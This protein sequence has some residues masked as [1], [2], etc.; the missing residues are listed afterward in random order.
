MTLFSSQP[1]KYSPAWFDTFLPVIP[2]LQTEKELDF[3]M[4][5]ALEGKRGRVLDLCCGEGRHAFPAVERGCEVV[6]VDNNARIVERMSQKM[7][8]TSGS[9]FKLVARDMRESFIDLDTFDSVWNLWQSFG[10]FDQDTNFSVLKNC[11]NALKSG[12]SLVLDI[13]NKDFFAD[14]M[15]ERQI[16]A[17]GRK[18]K[19][20]KTLEGDR[21]HVSLIYEDDRR[22]EFDWQLF[23]PTTARKF[24]EQAGYKVRGLY[25]EFDSSKTPS[26]DFPRMQLVAHRP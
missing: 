13:Y 8:G 17:G 11:L 19:E 18:V 22:E 1:N 15:G 14:K 24:L 20:V 10:F 12:G 4:E 3:L 23:N 25:S 9:R 6:A 2:N 16:M 26:S 7:L 21:L 5:I